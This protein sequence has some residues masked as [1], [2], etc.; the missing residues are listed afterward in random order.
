MQQQGGIDESVRLAS[1]IRRIEQRLKLFER[2]MLRDARVV[3]EHVV[4][5]RA[6]RHGFLRCMFHKRVRIEPA[7][8]VAQREHH[9]FA[10]NQPVR[11]VEIGASRCVFTSMFE[12]IAVI[13][14]SAPPRQAGQIGQRF[15]FGLPAA[16][17]AFV[18]LHHAAE[19]GRD[20]IRRAHRGG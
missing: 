4:Q 1:V 8:A 9:R 19:H 13:C 3:R 5:R 10:E 6:L 15:P 17:R 11:E 20:E 14:A 16:E 2:Q 7:D 18:L 12:T